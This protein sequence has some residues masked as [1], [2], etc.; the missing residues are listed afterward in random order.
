V[1]AAQEAGNMEHREAIK[2]I[3]E[4]PAQLRCWRRATFY[5]SGETLVGTLSSSRELDTEAG[6]SDL[7]PFSEAFLVWFD[8]FIRIEKEDEMTISKIRS[9]QVGH[10]WCVA[11]K[12]RLRV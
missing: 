11:T 3:S 10:D 5:F 8:L 7:P 6:R 4:E 12:T 1:R 9:P 2:L